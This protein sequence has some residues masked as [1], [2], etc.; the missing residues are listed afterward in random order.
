MEALNILVADDN[1][2]NLRLIETMLKR[3]GH[4]VTCAVDGLE[5][6][7]CYE[8]QQPDLVF[9]DVMMPGITGFEA[10][11]RIRAQQ[12]NNWRPII[13][14]SALTDTDHLVEGLEAGGDDYLFKP[15]N[16]TLLQSKL[17]SVERVLSMQ[18]R[19]FLAL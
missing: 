11:R 18:R 6:V 17:I 5:A 8:E 14:I 7:A 9:L 2:V 16:L 1:R 4:R 13:F 15:V 19:M 3:L 10:A 12:G